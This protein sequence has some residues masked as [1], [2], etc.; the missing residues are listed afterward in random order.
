M[1]GYTAPVRD[2]AFALEAIAGLSDV[3]GHCSEPVTPDL[4]QQILDEAGKFAGEVLAPLNVVGDREGSVLENGVVRTP[5]GFKE[6]FRQ[7][8]A[9]GWA[10]LAVE[11]SHGGQGLPG[12]CRQRCRKCA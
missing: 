11:T 10:G 8:A 1:S 5:A 12:W 3:A 9:G 7:Y 4:L 2:M 6:A